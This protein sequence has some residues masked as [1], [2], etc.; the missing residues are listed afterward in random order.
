MEFEETKTFEENPRTGPYQQQPP[1]GRARGYILQR[2]G[3]SVLTDT[4]LSSIEDKLTVVDWAEEARAIASSAP[5]DSLIGGPS[6]ADGQ[7]SEQGGG[8]GEA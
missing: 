7:S 6:S 8:G 5:C 2:G 1:R 4:D 3:S